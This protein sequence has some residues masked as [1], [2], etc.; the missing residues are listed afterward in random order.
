MS[1]APTFSSDDPRL[2]D[3]IRTIDL[4]QIGTLTSKAY[5]PS[6]S[7]SSSTPYRVCLTGFP[8][9]EGCRRNGGR[10]GAEEAPAVLRKFGNTHTHTYTTLAHAR[11]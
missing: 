11:S 9:D 3:W 5:I 10:V 7:S 4:E 1:A 2:G 6:S 8:Y